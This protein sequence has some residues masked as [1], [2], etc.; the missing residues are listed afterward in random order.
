MKV[1]VLEHS[2]E[3]AEDNQGLLAIFSTMSAA[4]KYVEKKYPR[5]MI[6]SDDDEDRN[7]YQSY[8]ETTVNGKFIQREWYII[9]EYG[10]L[11]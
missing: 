9:S 7:Y 1:F 3:Y 11:E 4:K 8:L 5:A 2:A 6:Q 10:V